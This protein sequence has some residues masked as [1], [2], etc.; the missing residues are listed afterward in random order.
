MTDWQFRPAR[1]HGLTPGARLRSPLREPGLGSRLTAALWQSATRAY[2][3]TA[4]RFTIHGR[5]NLPEPPFVIVANHASHLDA[6]AVAA[7]LPRRLAT[8]AF[9]LAAGDTFFTSGPTAAF[10]AY[11]INALPVWRNRTSARDMQ[12]LRARLH[13]DHA[14][15]I[16]FP[17]GTRTRTG[18][19]APFKPGLGALVAGTAV[20]VIPC[21]LAGAFHAWPATHHLPRPRPLTL[22]IGA[23]LRFTDSLTT[24]AGLQSVSAACEAAVRDLAAM[25]GNPARPPDPPA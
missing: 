1:D 7:A 14:I 5:E 9:A 2:L 19:I 10:A 23:P 8:R 3:R 24:R 4:H 22:R 17:E 13:E 11:A 6:L 18:N 16:L 15:L 25:D 20:P 21:H 12:S